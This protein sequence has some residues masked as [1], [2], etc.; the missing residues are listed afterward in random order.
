MAAAM[1]YYVQMFSN[2]DERCGI[3]SNSL[4]FLPREK[5]YPPTKVGS[6]VHATELQAFQPAPAHVTAYAEIG[7][8]Y[9][10]AVLV[11]CGL[12]MGLAWGVIRRGASPLF[13]AAGGAVCIFA[14]FLTQAGLVGTLTHSYG[15]VWYI[16]PLLLAVG[17]DA[18]ARASLS[19]FSRGKEHAAK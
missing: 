13:S 2:P 14:Y 17:I 8:G 3:E 16:A 7:P 6:H 15:L 9:A 18:V 11:L 19:Q 10:L 5:C 4:P 12:F 1:P